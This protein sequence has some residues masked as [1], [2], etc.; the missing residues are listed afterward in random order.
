MSD[1]SKYILFIYN[2]PSPKYYTLN[3][4]PFHL[5]DVLKFMYLLV[6]N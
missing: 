4:K 2:I 1:I 5:F 3:F 6:S